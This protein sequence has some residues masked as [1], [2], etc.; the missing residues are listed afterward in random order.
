MSARGP[1]SKRWR[2]ILIRA[3]MPLYLLAIVAVPS[4][5][6]TAPVLYAPT[7]ALRLFALSLAPAVFGISYPLFCGIL[8]RPT[9]WAVVAGRF[10]RDL[11]HPVYGPRRL[12]ALCWTALYY[13]TP[14]Y[15]VVLAIPWLKRV[16]FRLFGYT[17]STRFTVYPDTWL[18]DLPLLEIGEG[19]YLSNRAAI[20]TNMCLLDGSILVRPV[21]IAPGALIG[22]MS[23]CP[24]VSV[25]K[26]AQV[27][28]GVA[29]GAN[30][31]IGHRA[32]ISPCAGIN[33]GAKIGA[34]AEVGAGAY[35]GESARIGPGLRIPP[36]AIIP[37]GSIVNSTGAVRI[38]VSSATR[39]E[40]LALPGTQQVPL[41][42]A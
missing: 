37:D 33:H 25:G 6:A 22:H 26:R 41:D 14:I 30:C 23:L 11:G 42:G 24:G 7:A 40:L 16:T 4:A 13:C 28:V 12:H 18:R 2:R 36:C 17:G 8:S 20:G 5:V 32:R 38:L 27:G 39:P 3:L 35:V 10:P 1:H 34:D 15:H 29:V 31:R 21:R 9:R 19:A